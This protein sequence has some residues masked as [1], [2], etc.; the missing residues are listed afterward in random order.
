MELLNHMAVDGGDFMLDIDR[1]MVEGMTRLLQ[2][3]DFELA[4]EG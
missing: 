4:R 3:G 2:I 1:N